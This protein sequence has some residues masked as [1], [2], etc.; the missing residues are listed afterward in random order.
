[1]VFWSLHPEWTKTQ[2]L[3]VKKKKIEIGKEEPFT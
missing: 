2:G 1:M 3:E